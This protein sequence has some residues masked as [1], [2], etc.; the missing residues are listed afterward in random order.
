MSAARQSGDSY[1]VAAAARVAG[2]RAAAAG[3]E[4]LPED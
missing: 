3:S 2:L 4:S 1:A